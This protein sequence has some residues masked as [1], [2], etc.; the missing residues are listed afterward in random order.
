MLVVD[1]VRDVVEAG[2]DRM[3]GLPVEDDAVDH[4][5]AQRP[6]QVAA[7]DQ[8]DRIP[9]DAVDE[10]EHERGEDHRAEQNRRHG[11]VHT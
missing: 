2:S 5:L 7:G 6:E 3:L 10:A 11:R 9:A 8:P 4:V 1:A